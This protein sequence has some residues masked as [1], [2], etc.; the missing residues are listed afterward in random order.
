MQV[1]TKSMAN[2]SK[3]SDNNTFEVRNQDVPKLWMKRKG[4]LLSA[5]HGMISN[6]DFKNSGSYAHSRVLLMQKL[7]F[8]VLCSDQQRIGQGQQYVLRI[9][10]ITNHKKGYL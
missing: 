10:W 4:L 9:L 7:L 2:Q 1:I 6:P 8:S 5:K 3:G